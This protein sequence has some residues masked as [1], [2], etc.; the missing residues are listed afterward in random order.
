[1]NSLTMYAGSLLP[2]HDCALIQTISGDDGLH[3]IAKGY[4]DHHTGDQINR[5]V[6][7]VEGSANYG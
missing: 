7:P 3:W 2:G 4:Q 1:M 5:M 6:Q